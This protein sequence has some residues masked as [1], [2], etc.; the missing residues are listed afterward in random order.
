[1]RKKVV[2]MGELLLRLAPPGA[3]RF[4]QADSYEAV[5]GGGEA[6]V[7]VSL[8]QLGYE[9]H[10]LTKLPS[11]AIGQGGVNQLRRY[12]VHTEGIAR[13]GHRVGIYFLENTAGTRAS[14]VIYD[15]A[16]SAFAG[17][18]ADDFDFPAIF[19][20]C[21]WFHS[22]GISAAVSAE[23][24][25]LTLAAVQAAKEAGATVSFDVNYRASLW[26]AEESQAFMKKLMPYVD[27]CIANDEDIFGG[28]G[29]LPEGI[30]PG[31][32]L[33]AES[34]QRVQ[35]AMA[36]EFGCQYFAGVF[37]LPVDGLDK[38]WQG[39]LY[40]RSDFYLSTPKLTHIIDRVGIGD[41]FCAGLISAMLDE[42][43][44]VEAIQFATGALALKHTVPGD[45][46]LVS[47]EEM[48]R[49][50]GSAHSVRIIR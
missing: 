28:L 40:D 42:K 10:Y 16:A 47:R 48:E 23:G 4:L 3:K 21:A 22:S 13:G 46:N 49:A 12:G 1:M 39:L 34:F 26:T 18:S 38:V 14:N 36:E 27:V 25:A 44:P 41:A 31:A 19:Q 24:A 30:D 11:H 9:A 17:A 50:A 33:D 8:A 37:N 7:A 29:V 6:N 15:R 2:T 35:K 45:F 20:D 5:Y 43:S 32:D